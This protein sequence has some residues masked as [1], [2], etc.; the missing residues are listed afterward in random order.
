MSGLRSG[1]SIWSN[2]LSVLAKLAPLTAQPDPRAQW[3]LAVARP[4]RLRE[5]RVRP[6]EELTTWSRD[7]AYLTGVPYSGVVPL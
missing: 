4:A 2:R 1:D 3:G 7:L 5:H 6:L